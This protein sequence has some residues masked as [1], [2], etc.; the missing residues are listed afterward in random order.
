MDNHG[1]MSPVSAALASAQP[2]P[3]QIDTRPTPARRVPD[4]KSTRCRY[5]GSK[6]GCRAGDDCPFAHETAPHDSL[7]ASSGNPIPSSYINNPRLETAIDNEA[8]LPKDRNEGGSTPQASA[9]SSS[10]RGSEGTQPR[11]V[12]RPTPRAQRDNPREFELNQIRRRFHPQERSDEDGTILTFDIYPS[13]PDF[14]DL[15]KSLACAMHVPLDYPLRGTPSLE[16]V[17]EN[18]GMREKILIQEEFENITK[19]RISD[20]LLKQLNVLDRSLSNIFNMANPEAVTAPPD[21]YADQEATVTPWLGEVKQPRETAMSQEMEQARQRREKEITQLTS[22]LGRMPLFSKSSD[23]VSFTIPLN[24]LKPHLIPQSLRSVKTLTLVVPLLYPLEPCQVRIPGVNDNSAR[25][26]EALFEKHVIENSS[27]SLTSHVNYLSTMLHTL[28]AQPAKSAE[29]SRAVTSLSLNNKSI[30]DE[31]TPLSATAP[32]LEPQTKETEVPAEL[33]DRPHIQVIPRPPEWISPRQGDESD[34]DDSDYSGSEES[35]TDDDDDDEGG[36]VSIS[37]TLPAPTGRDVAL[38]FPSMELRGIEL[39]ELR[40]LHLTLKCE[41][42]KK[43]LDMKN[44]KIGDDGISVPPKRVESC[45]KCGNYLS[46]GFRRELMHPSSNRAGYLDLEGCLAFDLLPS[47]FIPTCSECS[48]TYPAPGIVAVRG[49]DASPVCRGCHHKMRFKIPEVKFLLV[50][51]GGGT[52]HTPAKVKKPKEALGIVAGQE[53][54][55]RGRCSHY[56]KSYRWFRFSCCLK[57]FPCDRCHD[58]ATDHPNEHANRMICGFCSREQIYRP[59]SCGIC[60]STLT[61]KTGSGFWEG[62]KGTRDR[63]RMNRKDPRK[64]KRRGGTA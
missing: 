38:S 59:E 2:H 54:P 20:T 51:A 47:T 4:R 49:D 52:S 17:D 48:T 6:K 27:A 44:I 60:H 46:V 35:A 50:S 58:A 23:G 12:Q 56:G 25:A 63:R 32:P 16:I 39:L 8:L 43:L 26:T 57:V 14:S 41:R 34:S 18:I 37:S 33:A 55:R 53:L 3:T 64:Y 62:G 30:A 15:L 28:A 19:T 29:L 11:V 24:P 5:F 21:S 31:I 61:R 13:D 10:P 36:G 42:C 22:R 45:K 9:F 7:A 40:A 1:Q